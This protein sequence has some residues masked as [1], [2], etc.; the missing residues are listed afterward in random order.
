VD[1]RFFRPAISARQANRNHLKPWIF[2]VKAKSPAMNST[3]SFSAYD[4]SNGLASGPSFSSVAPLRPTPEQSIELRRIALDLDDSKVLSEAKEG[5][6][7]CLPETTRLALDPT[8]PFRETIA[9][10]IAELLGTFTMTLFGIM[11]VS[12]GVLTGS[13]VGT[14][15]VAV[16]WVVPL[17]V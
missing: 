2:W 14:G 1:F 13:L 16:V 4:E 10:Y 17:Q 15:Q 8:S 12:A 9:P 6:E 7:G 11:S 5:N 3:E